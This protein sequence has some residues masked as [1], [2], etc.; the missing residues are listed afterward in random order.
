MG[1][2]H[3]SRRLLKLFKRR[4]TSGIGGNRR[5]R[6]LISIIYLEG[7]VEVGLRSFL[8]SPTST[9]WGEGFDWRDRLERGE[10]EAGHQMA[11]AVS[12]ATVRQAGQSTI[13]RQSLVLFYIIL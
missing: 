1:S 4:Y 2:G 7:G 13:V 12:R 5:A 10:E 9:H 6:V 8:V 11:A 3:E